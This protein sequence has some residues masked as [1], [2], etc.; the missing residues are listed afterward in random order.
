[1]RH[2]VAAPGV[3]HCESEAH[4]SWMHVATCGGDTLRLAFAETIVA[5]NAGARC[6]EVVTRPD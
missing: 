5:L 4:W 3:G 2:V 6:N 1:M